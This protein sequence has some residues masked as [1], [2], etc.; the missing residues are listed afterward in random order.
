[1]INALLDIEIDDINDLE[2]TSSCRFSTNPNNSR[3]LSRG[4]TTGETTPLQ[5]Q[6]QPGGGLNVAEQIKP[7]GKAGSEGKEPAFSGAPEKVSNK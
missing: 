4:E 2:D 5:L 7:A 3:V 6:L 1:M